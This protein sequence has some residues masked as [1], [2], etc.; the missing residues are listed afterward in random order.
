MTSDQIETTKMR[1][2]MRA[3]GAGEDVLAEAVKSGQPFGLRCG[4]ENCDEAA[5][6]WV[7]RIY[8]AVQEQ[9]NWEAAMASDPTETTESK[10]AF[11]EPNPAVAP[12]QLSQV[13]SMT[14]T[15]D[16]VPDRSWW[17]D[18]YKA[19]IKADLDKQPRIPPSD[20]TDDQRDVWLAG[21]DR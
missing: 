14:E 19:G 21:Y 15:T 5:G 20:L 2:S 11:L 3:V 4:C 16:E 8:W 6:E 13:E 1:L 10:L 9:I 17:K 12:S 18:M 7:E